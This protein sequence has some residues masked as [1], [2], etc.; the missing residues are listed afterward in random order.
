M[1]GAPNRRG[2]APLL[3]KRTRTRMH[4][5]LETRALHAG[6]GETRVLHGIDF[7]VEQGGVTALL[8]ANGAGKTTTLRA[9]CGMVRSE[10]QILFAGHRLERCTTEQIAGFGVAHVPEGRGTFV[11][12]TVEENLRLGGYTHLRQSPTNIERMYGYFPIL[13]QR[14]RQQGGALSGGEQQ[15]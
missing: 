15:M 5:L 11:G 14:R 7:S 3:V 13:A 1:K 6:Y 2:S 9:I 12:L 10:G 8:G 4:A